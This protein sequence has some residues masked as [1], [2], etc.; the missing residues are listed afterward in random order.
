M[1]EKFNK[2]RWFYISILAIIA[3]AVLS[4]FMF[5]G[6]RPLHHDEGMLA[7]FAWK[8]AFYREYIYTP[9]IHGPVLFYLTAFLFKIFGQTD[10]VLRASSA[11]AGVTIVS[12]PFFT[13]NY[14]SKLQ[15]IAISVLLLA[16]PLMLYYSRFLV[17]TAIEPVFILL[18]IFN[19]YA[20]FK[21][22]NQKSLIYGALSLALAFG[23]SEVTFIYSASLFASAIISYFVFRKWSPKIFKNAFAYLK[24]NRMDVVYGVIIFAL[25]YSAL[26]SV[27][28]T[29]WNSFKIGLPNPFSSEYGLGFW[30]S[31]NPKRLGGQ[32]WYYYIML[33][34]VYE[35]VV[36]AGF[37]GSAYYYFVRKRVFP[38]FLMIF[39]I[40]NLAIFSWAGEKF[41]WLAI[42]SLVPMIVVAGYFAGDIIKGLKRKYE[43]IFAGIM[44]VLLVFGIYSA[45]MLAYKNSYDTRE[46]AVYVQTPKKIYDK[47]MKIKEDCRKS[48]S[49]ALTDADISWPMSYIFRD[50]G[51][52]YNA[53]NLTVGENVKYLIAENIPKIDGKINADEWI[54]KSYQLREWWV[55]TDYP[56]G[57]TVKNLVKYLF[58]RQ[59]W[60]EKG[61]YDIMILDKKTK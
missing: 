10:A 12:I 2:N 33:F 8:L 51:G 22:P 46:L 23:T 15:K 56:N 21:K 38:I 34:A 39:S 19:I 49:C 17:H 20:F 1:I 58:T 11:L 3:L 13:G 24:K 18:L 47:F 25:V 54:S 48:Q 44:A 59:I 30:L 29:S 37:V 35:P 42:N 27:F 55:P 4:R 28:F 45:Y 36:L 57:Y 16:S 14:L 52:L 40:I 5:L 50:N 60:S 7:Y 9:Q 32:P 41:P 6:A 26:Y 43:K 31:Q 53:E 61:G